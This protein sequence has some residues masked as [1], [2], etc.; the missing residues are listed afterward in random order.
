MPKPAERLENPAPP[1]LGF[2]GNRHSM[3]VAL[4][5]QK[6]GVG[7]TTLALHL[8]GQWA[9]QGKRITLIDADP[10]GSRSTGPSSAHDGAMTA[11]SASLASRATRCIAR[12]PSSLETRVT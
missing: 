2:K 4:L 8:A 12:R 7:K 1:R 3:I 9:R 10:Q 6:G 5:N 11:C